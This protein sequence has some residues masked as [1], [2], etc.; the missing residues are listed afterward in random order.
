[1]WSPRPELDR[2]AQMSFGEFEASVGDA[3][4]LLIR[5]EG[6]NA[7]G[8]MLSLSD[9]AGVAAGDAN[10]TVEAGPMQ[11]TTQ[12]ADMDGGGAFG[13]RAGTGDHG[14]ESTRLAKIASQSHFVIQL[15]KRGSEGAFL[16][17]IT[18]GRTRNHDIVLRDP[19]VSKFHASVE[20]LD[21]TNVRVK[22]MGSRNHTQLNGS[23]INESVHAAPG[24]V[25]VFG[26]VEAT[27]CSAAGLWRCLR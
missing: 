18:L 26:S 2:Y 16:D 13:A 19:S 4:F 6:R 12:I 11:F 22:D 24:D 1:M 14:R 9:S 27:L 20:V 15:R 21:A 25:L 17:K 23:V 3:P 10:P 5:L 8:L 7:N